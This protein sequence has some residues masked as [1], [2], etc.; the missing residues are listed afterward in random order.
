MLVITYL[1]Q[2]CRYCCNMLLKVLHL[3]KKTSITQDLCDIFIKLIFIS[4]FNI[5]VK[6]FKK[7]INTFLLRVPSCIIWDLRHQSSF[8]LQPSLKEY[9]LMN[10]A[11]YMTTCKL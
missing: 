8:F 1:I 6:I 9:E 3:T 4:K 10:Y 7:C 2:H 11:S 5:F